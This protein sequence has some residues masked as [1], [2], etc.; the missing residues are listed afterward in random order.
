MSGVLGAGVEP[1]FL[2]WCTRFRPDP[3]ELVAVKELA[4]VEAG[5]F[6]EAVDVMLQE[7]G[8][9]HSPVRVLLAEMSVAAGREV[10]HPRPF[11]GSKVERERVRS[12]AFYRCRDSYW[13]RVMDK[14]FVCPRTVFRSELMDELFDGDDGADRV[15][16]AT[17]VLF[18][19][20]WG[21]FEGDAV[22][23]ARDI[24][25]SPGYVEDRLSSLAARGVVKL[26][27]APGRIRRVGRIVHHDQLDGHVDRKAH[28]SRRG[29]ARFPDESGQ[30]RGSRRQRARERE[31]QNEVPGASTGGQPKETSRQ[32]GRPPKMPENQENTR[33]EV[34]VPR[35]ARD[36]R[37]ERSG[38]DR[39]R[40]VDDAWKNPTP[41]KA[42]VVTA[43][44][45]TSK[46][47]VE[48]P[49]N[50]RGG[51]VASPGNSRGASVA[52]PW[53]FRGGQRKG[54]E[55]ENPSGFPDPRSEI[56]LSAGAS[57]PGGA[58]S[59][60]HEEPKT[61]TEG[62]VVLDEFAWPVSLDEPV[63]P[64]V[65]RLLQGEA[66]RRG[67]GV[68]ALRAWYWRRA[69]WP[70]EAAVQEALERIEGVAPWMLQ[71]DAVA[72]WLEQL[73]RES[74]R[75]GEFVIPKPSL[76]DVGDK[77]ERGVLV[78]F[79]DIELAVSRMLAGGFESESSDAP[80]FARWRSTGKQGDRTW[81]D[82]D[83]AFI[84]LL[85]RAWQ[86]ERVPE[87]RSHGALFAERW[88]GL[89]DDERELEAKVQQQRAREG[90]RNHASW[91]PVAEFLES[92][93]S[94]ELAV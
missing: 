89:D 91:P 58:R 70:G 63:G 34:E 21:L 62:P 45:T 3:D 49:R 77:G 67:M 39:G 51:A 74:F 50:S 55:M 43:S 35:S 4:E 8:E 15:F 30:I 81:H 68:A 36:A 20:D 24:A 82:A 53:D 57:A 83:R 64:E 10:P 56:L 29:A 12:G 85:R 94:R 59:P 31:S 54:E 7:A 48:N 47:P 13:E 28:E 11:R 78:R 46:E 65:Q 76:L 79:G 92:L 22:A 66:V 25:A 27:H 86:G 75:R 52:S 18:S 19:D 6:V 44:S 14:F 87:P 60:A 41:E 32:R 5:A 71:P 9:P 80:S 1:L 42:P 33:N 16:Y 93:K 69:Y 73:P 26:Y 2:A 88:A 61:M 90:L 40:S 84:A 37:E 23:L 38:D 17:L 72:T